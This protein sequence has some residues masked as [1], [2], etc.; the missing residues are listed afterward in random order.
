[1][2][3]GLGL[4]LPVPKKGDTNEQDTKSMLLI[5]TVCIPKGHN[6]THAVRFGLTVNTFPFQISRTS[7]MFLYLSRDVGNGCQGVGT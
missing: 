7:L 4:N 1:M 5:L 2:I 3:P 6:F